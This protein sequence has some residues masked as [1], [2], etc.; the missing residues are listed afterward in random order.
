MCIVAIN[1]VYVLCLPAVFSFECV[2]ACLFLAHLPVAY[3]NQK[4]DEANHRRSQVHKV[5]GL[6]TAGVGRGCTTNWLNLILLLRGRADR[7]AKDTI[8][9]LQGGQIILGSTRVVCP[10]GSLAVRGPVLAL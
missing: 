5:S 10:L 3:L 8:P 9:V 6:H 2:A 4:K 7:E 1:A